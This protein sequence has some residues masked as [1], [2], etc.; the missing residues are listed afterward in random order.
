[1]FNF[2]STL[3]QFSM[4]HIGIN[5][6]DIIII[7]VV[8]FYAHEGYTLG[9]TLAFL[10]L[11]SFVLSFVIALKFYGVVSY[12]LLN[13][14]S[15][16]LGVANAAGF[17]ITALV[18]EIVLSLL[19]RKLL[20]RIPA[21]PPTNAIYRFFKGIDHWLGLLPGIVSAFIVLSFILSVVV[22]LPSSPL[23]KNLVTDSKMSS[24][25]IAN[26]SFFEKRL[27]DI[28]GGALSETL[29]FLTVQP[30]SKESVVLNYK[31]A[32]GKIDSK[33]EGE[34]FRMVN[35]ERAR[36]GV[37]LLAFDNNLRDVARAHSDDM[38][39]RGYFSHYTPDGLSPFDRME[40]AGIEFSFA[41]ENLALAPSTDLAMQ[42]LMNSPGH[43]K[44]ILSP[45]FKK[46]GVGA[47]DGG[48]YGKMYS[49]EFTD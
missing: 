28:F 15:L 32:D 25:L 31:V 3:S 38:F 22:S 46:V 11:T 24:K 44:N 42:G 47:I 34:M 39:K 36:A 41:G 12:F 27:N 49:Q 45:S 17:F 1:M 2:A 26:T 30:Q 8:L 10:D 40:K 35:T 20:S 7:L 19:F 9:F 4:P 21:I 16:P 43:R 23:I 6:L 29:N 18:S 5:F 48:I 14:F 13:T 37:A 33:A